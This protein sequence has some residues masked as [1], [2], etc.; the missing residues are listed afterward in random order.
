MDLLERVKKIRGA[1]EALGITFTTKDNL[2][3]QLPAGA[4]LFGYTDSLYLCF[5]AGYQETVFAVHD[6]PEH[7][8]RAWPVAYDFQEFLRLIFA[9]GS[10]N[11]AA[12]SGIIT[13]DEYGREFELEAQKSHAGLNKLSE[14][15]S[16][17]PIQNPYT[18]THTIGQVLDCSRIIRKEAKP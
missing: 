15:L 13:E 8:W 14:L 16:L 12:I 18:Y 17:M 7:E 6:M 10:A 11:L 4:K 1:E 2:N 3:A 5:V 9:C